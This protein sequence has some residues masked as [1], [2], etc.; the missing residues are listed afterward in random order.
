M[1]AGRATLA[2]EFVHHLETGRRGI[3]PVQ[4]AHN[5]DVIAILERHPL[6][7][8]REAEAVWRN[9]GWWRIG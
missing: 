2:E 5:V 1:P 9:D 7:G 6:G 8:E 3:P 4:L